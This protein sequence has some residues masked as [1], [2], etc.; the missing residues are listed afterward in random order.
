MTPVHYRQG[1]FPPDE[2]LDWKVL[3]PQ[4]GQA[5]DSLGRFAEA[6]D[7]IPNSSILLSPLMNQEAVLSSRIEGTKATLEDVLRFEAGQ[8]PESTERHDD[9]QEIINYRT[10]MQQAQAILTHQH[11][12]QYVIRTVHQTLLRGVRGQGKSPGEFRNDQNWIGGTGSVESATF[13]PV[14]ALQ[15]MGAMECWEHYLSN[16][17]RYPLVKLGVLHAEFEAIHPFRDGNGRLGRI[18]IPLLMWKYNL[19]REPVFYISE[20]LEANR[21]QYYDALLAVSRDDDW[22]GWCRFFLTAVR[23]QADTDLVKAKK[24]LA[25]YETMKHRIAELSKSQFAIYALDWIFERPIF[26]TAAYLSESNIPESS[27]RRILRLMRDAGILVEVR[28]GTGRRPALF[29]FA[30]ILSIAEGRNL[31]G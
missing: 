9:I 29:L 14:D 3:A 28:S 17:T 7:N 23:V 1:A 11:L 13:V 12:S 16:D 8:D 15:L 30:E 25:L 6:L 24:I 2:R 27:A 31:T 5:R 19:I 26:T 22:T 10:A 20:Y 21:E 4:M 18:M